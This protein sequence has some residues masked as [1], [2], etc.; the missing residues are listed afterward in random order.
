VPATTDA[1]EANADLDREQRSD[2][3]I[4]YAVIDIG[5]F[6]DH[7]YLER[8]D[9]LQNLTVAGPERLRAFAIEALKAA[10][11][12]G[13]SFVSTLAL[14]DHAALHPLFYRDELLVS[15]STF[16]SDEHL[17]HFRER[18]HIEIVDDT[19]YFYLQ[20]AWDAEEIVMRVVSDRLALPPLKQDLNWL[21]DFLAKEACELGEHIDDFDGEGFVS[22]R[23]RLMTGALAFNLLLKLY[24]NGHVPGFRADDLDRVQLL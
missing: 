20:Q 17:A 9:D 22:E 19:H 23:H 14:A 2:G 15:E 10:E 11:A 13:H 24:E 1:G 4:D 6:P 3:P 18:L 8:R 7:R 5:I 21:P 12:K 16:V